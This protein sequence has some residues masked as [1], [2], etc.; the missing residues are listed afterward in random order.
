MPVSH[1]INPPLVRGYDLLFQ[2]K[3]GEHPIVSPAADKSLQSIVMPLSFGT[4]SYDLALRGALAG[5]LPAADEIRVEDFLAAQRYALDPAPFN[6]LA[7]HVAA[8]PAPLGARGEYFAQVAVQTGPNR[9]SE[10]PPAR[11]LVALD[12]SSAMAQGARWEAV[13]RALAKLARDM[14]PEDRLSLIGFAESPRLL[15]ERASAAELTALLSDDTLGAPGGSADLPAAMRLASDLIRALPSGESRQVVFITAGREDFDDAAWSSCSAALA[16]LSGARIPWQI[17]RLTPGASDSQLSALAAQGHGEIATADSAVAIHR[18]LA[19]QLIGRSSPV[20]NRVALKISFNPQAVT[21]YRLLGNESR[22]LTGISSPPLEVDLEA[23]E[24]ATGMLQLWLKPGQDDQLALVE[25]SW[26]DPSTDQPLR[27]AKV[28]RRA[29]IASTFAKAPGWL[30]QGVI[31][32][33]TAEALRGGYFAPTGRPFGQVL[34]LAAQ[35]DAGVA[36]Q[37]DFQALLSVLRQADKRR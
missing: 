18:A 12:T 5:Q 29:E 16:K 3:H 10:H 7:L 36:Q 25:L 2:L 15:A 23:D 33:A 4:A 32:A 35:V 24:L 31:A 27:Q 17:I 13:R 14:A 20:A 19:K 22:T 1:G 30:Q 8:T 21:G 9:F 26:S 34:A 37:P 11:L 28:L 6:A